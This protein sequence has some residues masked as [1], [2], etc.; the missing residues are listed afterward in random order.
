MSEPNDSALIA[1]GGCALSA[2]DLLLLCKVGAAGDLAAG[3]LQRAAAAARAEAEGLAVTDDEVEEAAGAFFAERD[4]FE[5]EAI[6]NWLAGMKL[7]A[8][9]LRCW[10]RQGL[11]LDQLKAALVP[12]AAVLA[13]FT[14]VRQDY[15]RANLE[16][17]Q[18][19]S[20]GAAAEVMLALREGEL[21][22]ETAVKK[23]GGAQTR[24]VRRSEA[25]EEIAAELFTRAPGELAGPV[26]TDD[27]LF[28]IYRVMTRTEP[29]LTDELREQV[30]D[31]L[32]QPLL[33][34]PFIKAPA[35]FLR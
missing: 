7:D 32:F 22:W 24:A 13:H 21:R 4:L 11:L 25:P 28:A 17:I 27:G 3:A 31:E 30:R 33:E 8:A 14:A 18:Y 15:A 2:A 34:A 16:I 20:A 5:A 29:E 26:E 6:A 9:A 35:R 23:A 19:A 1:G 10:L 12:D